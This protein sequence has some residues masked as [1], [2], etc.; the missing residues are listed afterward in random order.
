M[1]K[2]CSAA[3]ESCNEEMLIQQ[4]RHVAGPGCAPTDYV[5]KLPTLPVGGALSIYNLWDQKKQT[6]RKSRRGAEGRRFWLRHNANK[7][8]Q[9]DVEKST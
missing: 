7:L 3:R 9:K 8:K 4:R 6:K 2:S 1:N 5:S